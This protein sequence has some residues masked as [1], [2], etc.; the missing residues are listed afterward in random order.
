MDGG[1]LAINTEMTRESDIVEEAQKRFRRAA[2]WESQARNQ[3]RYDMWFNYGDNTNNA[4]WDEAVFNTRKSAKRPSQTV[5]RVIKYTGHVINDM[6][7]NKASIEI[8]AVGNGASHD[9]AEIME[10]VVRHIEY[11]SNAQDAYKQ[12]GHD[13]II[14][15]MGYWRL[16]TDYLDSDSFDQE[17]YIKQIS[18]ALSVY[19]DIDVPRN[20]ASAGKWAFIF[21]DVDREVIEKE[22]PDIQIASTPVINDDEQDYRHI[23]AG[24]KRVRVVEYFR[25]IDEPDTL[26]VLSDGSFM[27]ESDSADVR[28]LRRLSVK[29]RDIKTPKVEWFKIAGY[30]I[31]EERELVGKYIPIV[32]VPGIETCIDGQLDRRGLLRDMIGPQQSLN[33]YTSGGI[34]Y[35]AMQTKS[36]WTAPAESIEGY[37]TYWNTAN[38]VNHAVL[39]YKAFDDEGNALPPPQRVD[40]P[41]YP[42]A[43]AEG[44]QGAIADMQLTSGITEAQMGDPGNE[45][46]GKGIDARQR[47]AANSTYNYPERFTNALT[48]TG[49]IIV[50]MLPHIYDTP[51]VM[52]ILAIDGKESTIQIDPSHP[53]AHSPVQ[54]LDD[55]SMSPEQ[56]AAIFNPSVGQYD[57]VASVGPNYETRR[58]AGFEALGDIIAQNEGLAP[59]YMDLWAGLGDF[60]Y[61]D[62]VAERAK[63]LLPPQ[64]TGQGP[65]PQVVQLQ[66]LLAQQHG[67]MVELTQ[68]NMALEAKALNETAQKQIDIYKA[69]TERLTALGKIDPVGIVPVARGL[70]SEI[71]SHPI[72]PL[73]EAHAT[74]AKE[75]EIAINSM[76]PPQQGPNQQ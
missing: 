64:A 15:G 68:K 42:Q 54:G 56:V 23:W 26:H 45:R 2:E 7:Q 55:E 39:P 48:H 69:E 10:G 18:D 43:F 9:S 4:Q 28:S 75:L 58:Q 31:L 72:N 13:Q 65:N 8:R 16:E 27:K 49:I 63:N 67:A 36:S 50:G 76:E 44:R 6:L 62:Q 11:I 5:N 73:I 29:Q 24:E 35:V 25:I 17:I 57:V 22:Y 51:R 21:S 70:E 20:S 33:W 30:E 38:Q 74:E 3:W 71:V 19:C 40:P 41:A 32:R 34:E 46:S 59:N 37:E 52:K 12:A 53:Q 47:A 1:S 14:S 61:S 60:E 66:Q